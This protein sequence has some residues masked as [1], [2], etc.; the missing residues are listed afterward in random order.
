MDKWT[1]RILTLS[2]KKFEQLTFFPY[3]ILCTETGSCQFA[4]HRMV[5]HVVTQYFSLQQLYFLHF[6]ILTS[7]LQGNRMLTSQS[8]FFYYFFNFYYFLSVIAEEVW[9]IAT[10]LMIISLSFI[11]YFCFLLE[12]M[13]DKMCFIKIKLQKT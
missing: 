2:H 11:S 4:N 3:C 8:E 5:Q 1:Y 9:T 10:S 7:H 13:S 12:I 6:Y